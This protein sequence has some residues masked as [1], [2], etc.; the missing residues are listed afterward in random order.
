MTPATIYILALIAAF[1][2]LGIIYRIEGYLLNKQD[3]A[4]NNFNR[5]YK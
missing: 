1:G 4:N 5:D 3:K 2:G